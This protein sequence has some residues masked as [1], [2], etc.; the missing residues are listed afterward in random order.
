MQCKSCDVFKYATGMTNDEMSVKIVSIYRLEAMNVRVTIFSHHH[1]GDRNSRYPIFKNVFISED[2]IPPIRNNEDIFKP[3]A[4]VSKLRPAK[5][6]A[7]AHNTFLKILARDAKAYTKFGSPHLTPENCDSYHEGYYGV[8]TVQCPRPNISIFDGSRII[9]SIVS[10]RLCWR[11][12]FSAFLTVAG[13]VSTENIQNFSSINFE[14]ENYKLS[15]LSDRYKYGETKI[16]ICTLTH[17]MHSFDLLYVSGF[18]TDKVKC[19]DKIRWSNCFEKCIP[20]P[21]R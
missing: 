12:S 17:R 6:F 11:E 9:Y 2:T 7:P 10:T 4:W 19:F 3:K 5:L 15:Y 14:C 16:K 20:H 21:P 1:H 13:C 8:A 18:K